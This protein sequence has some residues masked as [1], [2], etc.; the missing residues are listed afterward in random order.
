MLT[1][2]KINYKHSPD[3]YIIKLNLEANNYKNL[4]SYSVLS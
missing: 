3:W 4:E 1:V 2:K